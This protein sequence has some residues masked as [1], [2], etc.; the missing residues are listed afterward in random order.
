MD[1]DEML[2]CSLVSKYPFKDVK[3]VIRET[4]IH[5]A[6]ITW[7]ARDKEVDEA[8]Q[9]GMKEV[10]EW[11]DERIDWK[12]ALDAQLGGHLS[13]NTQQWQAFLKRMGI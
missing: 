11:I 5:Q 3:D 9:A 10:V 7:E 8:K 2:A 12:F 13:I 4:C 6:E 1:E